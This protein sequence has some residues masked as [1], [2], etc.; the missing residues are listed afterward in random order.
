MG[1]QGARDETGSNSAR[2]QVS[3]NILLL[4]P[5]ILIILFTYIIFITMLIGFGTVGVGLIFLMIRSTVLPVQQ[6]AVQSARTMRAVTMLLFLQ[7]NLVIMAKMVI[8][9]IM[10]VIMMTFLAPQSGALKISAYRDFLP[11]HPIPSL[12]LIAFEH[13]SLSMVI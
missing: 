8:M 9:V 7:V 3:L 4:I 1:R 12:P 11:S 6:F 13:L 2:H 10:V 5:T